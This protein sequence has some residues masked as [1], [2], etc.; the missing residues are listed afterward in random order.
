M[1]NHYG[2]DERHTQVSPS[3]NKPF[4]LTHVLAGC[5]VIVILVQPSER[6]KLSDHR[7][8]CTE[9]VSKYAHAVSGC[10]PPVTNHHAHI[11]NHPTTVSLSPPGRQ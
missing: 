6:V 11:S 3:V 1:I 9:Y 4:S 10:S 7:P 2:W 5:P 8:V